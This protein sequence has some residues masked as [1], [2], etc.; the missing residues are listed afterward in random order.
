MD[1]GKLTILNIDKSTLVLLSKNYVNNHKDY[2]D[3]VKALVREANQSR[4][5]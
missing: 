4:S 1:N 2:Y 5:Y 3:C